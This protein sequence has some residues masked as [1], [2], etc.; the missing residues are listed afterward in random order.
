MQK[1]TAFTDLFIKRPV[2]AIV[3]SLAIV[4]VGIQAYFSLNARQFPKNENAVV[5]ITTTYIGSDAA[6]VRGFITTPIERAIATSDGIDYIESTSR[7]G[8]STIRAH[9][10]LNFNGKAALS[11]ISTKVDQVRSDLPTGSEV[12][13]LSVQTAGTQVGAAYLNFQS[14]NHK[15]NE[16]TDYLTRVVQ[17]RLS[18]V[19]GVQ[20]A[21]ILGARN[22]AMRIWLDP[23]KMAA[24]DIAPAQIN[25]AIRKNNYLSTIGQTKGQ[26]VS[27]SMTANTDL[28]SVEEF[29]SIVLAKHQ[30]ALVRMK[31]VAKVE[32]GSEAYDTDVRFSGKPAVFLGIWVLPDANTIDVI[33]EVRAELE[34]IKESLPAGMEAGMDYDSSEYIKDSI[35]EVY[36]TLSETLAIVVL[37]IF[38]FMG[39]LRA[40]VVPVVAI[41]ISLI[42]GFFL[43]Q[44]FGFSLNLL[45]LLAVV[46]SVGLVVDDAI[47]VVENVERH[48]RLGFSRIEAARIAVHQLIG[49]VIATTLVL[50]AVYAPIALQGGLT[51]VY[52]KEFALTLSGAVI[53]SSVVA[54][55]LS[56]MMSSRLLKPKGKNHF[57]TRFIN[58]Q[59]SRL[60]V[61]YEGV[62]GQILEARLWVYVVW[63]GLSIMA[64]PMFLMSPRELAPIEDQNFILGLFETP[65]NSSLEQTSHYANQVFEIWK[66][67]PEYDFTFQ[68]TRPTT[69]F[70]GMGLKPFSERTR[71]VHQVVAEC[72]EKVDRVPGIKSFMLAPSALPGGGDFPVEFVIATTDET[73]NALEYAKKLQMAATQSGLFAFPPKIDLKY[74]LK[75]SEIKL[76]YNKIADLGLD[77]QQVGRDLSAALG[78][79]YVN[80]FSMD[81]RSYKVIPQISRTYRLNPDQLNTLHVSGPNGSLIPLNLIASLVDS[82]EP[83]SLNRFQQLNAIKLSG[84]TTRTVETAL[85]FLEEQ[86]DAILPRGYVVDYTGE[87]RQL[88]KEGGNSKFLQ[89]FA[90]AI[91]VVFL[92]LAAQFNSFRDPFII[93]LGSVP[94]AVFGA[95]IFTFLKMPAP[96]FSFFTDGWTTTFNIYTQVGLVTLVG[97]IA[98]NSIL[99]VEFANALQRQG[100]SKIDAVKEAS[101]IR[102]RPILMTTAA[103]ILG[104]FP[105]VLVSGAGAAARN[106]IG[107]VLVGGLSIGTIFTLFIIPAIYIL[108]AADQNLGGSKE[109][110][111][112]SVRDVTHA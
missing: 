85:S 40:V 9:L 70:G 49:P 91:I 22:Y 13:I 111:A 50:V 66:T 38:L 12:P 10:K 89:T 74:D 76:D 58:H 92:V 102:L 41:P 51:G 107:L 97:L 48:I 46:L 62:L 37:V 65:A 94:L 53:V 87:S 100:Y 79:N 81:G 75:Q 21:E 78:G 5:T 99:I 30:G 39:S 67:M 95:S 88:R 106:S 31:D 63:L 47:V 43:M 35:K 16:I 86:A 44:M 83:R 71:S 6:L 28:N 18:S 55:T 59:F 61:I 29:E 8:V 52:F 108:I 17:P 45:T 1:T 82:I 27:V 57:L 20:R 73:E 19:A 23:K 3:V 2:L 68:L 64:V 84:I 69:A 104:H 93:L 14:K 90:L 77:V 80:R 54:L 105:L 25:A 32:L 7:A 109:H 96:D 36:S 42:G 101:A 26:Y 110:E 56:P 60:Q 33:A 72:Q 98:K 11:E 112:D 4:I 15:A 34:R 24:F 103:T